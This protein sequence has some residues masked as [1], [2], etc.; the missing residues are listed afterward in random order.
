VAQGAQPPSPQGVAP[1]GPHDSRNFSNGLIG[2]GQTSAFHT[3]DSSNT[4][5]VTVRYCPTKD[6]S[7][8]ARVSTG[9]RPGGPNVVQGAGTLVSDFKP[10]K[11][12]NTEV[13]L[14]GKAMDG[15]LNFDASVYHID[16]TSRPAPRTWPRAAA[17]WTPRW[18]PR[19]RRSC[20]AA[21]AGSALPA[22]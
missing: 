14:K 5:Q 15:R 9:Y 16:W 20:C 4:Y 19:W 21:A 2:L 11:V 10:D 7:T 22:S 8:F 18:P 13:G 6:L 3:E 1:L 17:R 12:T